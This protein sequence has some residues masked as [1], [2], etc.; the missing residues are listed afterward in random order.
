[1][2]DKV[3]KSL[4][5]WGQGAVQLV[6]LQSEQVPT[7]SHEPC[8]ANIWEIKATNYVLEDLQAQSEKEWKI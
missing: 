1:M 7:P 3:S 8:S 5:E 4:L 2:T 6:T